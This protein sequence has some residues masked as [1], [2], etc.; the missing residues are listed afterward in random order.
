[1]KKFLI[2]TT[3]SLSIFSASNAME[4]SPMDQALIA[5]CSLNDQYSAFLQLEELLQFPE[6]FH[7]DWNSSNFRVSNNGSRQ[8]FALAMEK[9]HETTIDI[10]LFFSSKLT[11]NPK[12]L[13]FDACKQNYA[14]LAIATIR[15]ISDEEVARNLSL[16]AVDMAALQGK[17]D[18]LKELISAPEISCHLTISDLPKKGNDYPELTDGDQTSILQTFITALSNHAITVAQQGN[19]EP[20][21]EL[22]DNQDLGASLLPGHL[23]QIGQTV[24]ANGQISDGEK[25]AIKEKLEATAQANG[26]WWCTIL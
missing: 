2:I 24:S 4:H 16:Y 12:T 6:Y 7:D 1:M 25:E 18:Y 5:A 22:L 15:N 8:A 13:I 9:K 3:A 21:K 14:Y 26:Y 17:V 11:I 10:L 23:Q 20:V 19:L